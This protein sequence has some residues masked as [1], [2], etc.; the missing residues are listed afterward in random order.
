M[1]ASPTPPHHWPDPRSALDDT[2][3]VAG[4]MAAT[5]C[6]AEDLAELTTIFIQEQPSMTAR[7]SRA[8]SAL[9]SQR[10]QPGWEDAVEQLRT[11]AHEL[12]TSFGI[13]GARHAEGYARHTQLRIRKSSAL[14]HPAPSEDDL[15]TAAAALLGSVDR[16]A[17][18][19]KR[20]H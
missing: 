14:S 2:L 1:S 20:G 10:G 9:Q 15:L 19:L 5:G 13:V 7:L 11:A 17:A 3:D 4:V 16:V 12:T 8:L 18:L 6:T